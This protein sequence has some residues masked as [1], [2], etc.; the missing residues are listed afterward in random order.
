MVCNPVTPKVIHVPD[1][2]A[3]ATCP[4]CSDKQIIS[5]HDLESSG[6]AIDGSAEWVCSICKGIRGQISTS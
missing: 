1:Y 3:I 5:H 4:Y 6:R 2:H